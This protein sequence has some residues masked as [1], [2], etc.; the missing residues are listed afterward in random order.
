MQGARVM[1]R[2][3]ACSLALAAAFLFLAWGGAGA[4]P[5]PPAFGDP[6]W[7]RWGDGQAELDGYDLTFSRYG[8]ARKGTA[9]AIFVT[10]TFSNAL[11]VKSDPGRHP[12]ADEFPV[13]KLNLV[14]DFPTGI[15]D[16]NLMT[17]AFA[18]LAP[19]NGLPAGGVTK[20]SFSGQ[21]WCGHVFAQA[22]LAPDSIRVSS[23]SYFDGEADRA[24]GLPLPQ[25]GLAE[26]A[27][28]LW[29]RGFAGPSLAP[30]EEAAVTI[31]GSLR[32][33]RLSHRPLG[34]LS[35]RL[36]HSA[37]REQVQVPAGSFQVER[38][39]ATLE[40]HRVWSFD[41]EVAAPRRIVRWNR[42]EEGG[43]VGEAAELLAGARLKY[44]EMN[45]PGFEAQ[46]RQLG[47][48][49]RPRRTP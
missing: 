17:S 7:Q 30:G 37:E 38:F 48:A 19:V 1:S 11:R 44:W 6:F 28:L 35:A 40:N 14:Q 10:E 26:D 9:V 31:L 18:A 29:A 45:G 20:V 8:A 15:Y 41:V 3:A 25:G 4:A 46:L 23:H 24:L 13:M 12:A 22:L 42:R 27:L 33:A 47:L 36:R 39:T 32:L 49:P 43:E 21:E 34:L 16:Y 5:A 2:R